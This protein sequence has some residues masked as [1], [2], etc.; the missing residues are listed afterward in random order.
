M[1]VAASFLL[2]LL[3][4]AMLLVA[5]VPVWKHS[6]EGGDRP[7]HHSRHEHHHHGL[8]QSQAHV[9]L[10]FF[11]VEFTMPV[12]SDDEDDA[13]TPGQ[14]TFLVAAP[15]APGVDYD[16][17]FLLLPQP[18]LELGNSSPCEPAFRSKTVV[19]APLCDTARHERSGVQ[20]I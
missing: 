5:G 7:H 2:R 19:A 17:Q 6:H 15:M 12:G 13:P 4:S 16:S 8:G 14:M 18:T 3:I 10:A 20:L 1:V 11:G 9:H